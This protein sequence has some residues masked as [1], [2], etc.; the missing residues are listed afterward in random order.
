MLTRVSRE[1]PP[2]DIGT[3][4]QVRVVRL[5]GCVGQHQLDEGLRL[6]GGLFK[7]EFNGGSHQLQ[8]HRSA[9]LGESL[10]KLLQKLVYTS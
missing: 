1:E 5:L 6:F 3:I 4:T 2:V 7:E 10:Q 8:L 9:F